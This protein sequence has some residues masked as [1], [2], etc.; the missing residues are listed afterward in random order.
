ML[1][2][3]LG[4]PPLSPLGMLPVSPPGMLL[5]STRA[6]CK[7]IRPGMRRRS[8]VAPTLDPGDDPGLPRQ[9]QGRQHVWMGQG[10]RATRG[11]ASRT[12]PGAAPPRGR[13]RQ[14]RPL[15]RDAD[16][17]VCP[18]LCPCFGGQARSRSSQSQK[19]TDEVDDEPAQSR[20]P[21]MVPAAKPGTPACLDGTPERPP[22]R[23]RRNLQ[24]FPARAM[25]PAPRR[26]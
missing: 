13:H 19:Q 15:P 20:S 24:S 22:R 12:P 26:R 23:A 10:G 21:P 25:A 7:R 17:L 9:N 1:A 2:S 11:S 4:M 3:P 18:P 5:P 14:R 6:P 16:T 8:G